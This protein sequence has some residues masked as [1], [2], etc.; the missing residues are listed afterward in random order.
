[1]RDRIHTLTT[2]A[3]PTVDVPHILLTVAAVLDEQP[4]RTLTEHTLLLTVLTVAGPDITTGQLRPVWESLPLGPSGHQH[5][6]YADQL[7]A[8]A[9]NS[10]AEE[11]LRRVQGRPAPTAKP[12]QAVAA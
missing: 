12:R 7:I 2:P 6:A 3:A 1:M 5:S 11:A 9:S 8:A 4:N 10:D